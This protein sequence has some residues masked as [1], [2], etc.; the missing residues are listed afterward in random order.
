[1]MASWFDR[2]A[3]QRI[4]QHAMNCWSPGGPLVCTSIAYSAIHL[5]LILIPIWHTKP[6]LHVKIEP[7]L[8][9]LLLHHLCIVLACAPSQRLQ[10]HHA[11]CQ[12]KSMLVAYA[13]R[14]EQSVRNPLH[15]LLPSPSYPSPSFQKSSQRSRDSGTTMLAFPLPE[16][17]NYRN[18]S[19]ILRAIRYKLSKK[20]C[21]F[22]R[23]ACAL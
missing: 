22:I 12:W 9:S 17:R 20:E 3:I 6:I 8:R 19:A 21:I 4:P 13:T 18:V 5:I 11:E 16:K 7:V 14:V 10:P 1:M 23:R 2:P 15:P